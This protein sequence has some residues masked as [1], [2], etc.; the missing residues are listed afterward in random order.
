MPTWHLTQDG[1]LTLTAPAGLLDD[2]I[3]RTAGEGEEGSRHI[4]V[5]DTP[6]A[7]TR[8]EDTPTLALLD[9]GAWIA[10]DSIRLR[11]QE[12]ALDGN[13][14]LARGVGQL[15]VARGA[16]AE[17]LLTIACALM[18]GR[19]GR[20]LVHAAGLIAPDGG[21]WLLAGDTHSGKSSTLATLA[22]GG[23]G[24]VADDQVMLRREGQEVRGAGWARSL[25][26]DRGYAAGRSTGERES[27][28][29]PIAQLR[30]G[31]HPLGGLLLPRV[32]A[33]R[34]TVLEPVG[35]A[36]GFVELVRQSPWLMADASAT[37]GL[38][39]VFAKVATLPA[40]RL[41]LGVD[42]YGRPDRLREVLGPLVGLA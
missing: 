36:E 1:A 39:A 6:L 26:L 23:W 35:S 42:T 27:T 2:W 3:P 14:D 41:R 37:A 29:G 19:M 24:W 10:G 11:D 15:G 18:L 30:P 16:H 31:E 9:V 8:P 34:E 5:R 21:L 12:G 32:E 28:A 7:L 40:A 4:T 17:P 20:A 25:N 33:D 13:V 22:A 38:S